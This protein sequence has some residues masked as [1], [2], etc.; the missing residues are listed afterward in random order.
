MG[1]IKEK[2]EELEHK[3]PDVSHDIES[4]LM[5]YMGKDHH[6]CGCGAP[7]EAYKY[8]RD[9]LNMIP[10]GSDDDWDGKYEKREEYFKDIPGIGYFTYYMIDNMGLTE[11]GGSVP[12][13]LTEKGIELRDMLNELEIDRCDLELKEEG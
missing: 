13:W 3:E 9:V 7:G 5:D 2:L 4:V 11:H 6:F 1:I 10:A 12:G 8:L